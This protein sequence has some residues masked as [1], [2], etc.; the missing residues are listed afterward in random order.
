MDIVFEIH[1]TSLQS[2]SSTIVHEHLLHLFIFCRHVVLTSVMYVLFY[3]METD[4]G[5]RKEGREEE[6]MHG[7]LDG[8][9]EK[10]WLGGHRRTDE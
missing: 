1:F 3:V 2:S 8:M 4:E 7:P 9:A 10:A 6:E 5:R